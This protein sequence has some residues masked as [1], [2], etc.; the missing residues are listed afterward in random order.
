MELFLFP[1]FMGLGGHFLL[2]YSGPNMSNGIPDRMNS[3]GRT[4][5][6]T[7]RGDFG[8]NVDPSTSPRV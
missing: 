1:G 5:D 4:I 3:I 7:V 2:V 6:L 8:N